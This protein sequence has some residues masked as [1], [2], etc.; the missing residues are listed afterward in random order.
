MENL[1]TRRTF[2]KTAGAAALAAGSMATASALAAPAAPP[3]LADDEPVAVYEADVVIAGS[4]GCG[5][6][7]AARAAQLG[8]RAL[9]VEQSDFPGGT[10]MCTEGLFAVGTH[11]QAE[12]GIDLTVAQ[13]FSQSMDFN[14]WEADGALAMEFFSSSADNFDW[15]EDLGVSF[16]YAIPNGASLPTWHVYEKDDSG[17]PGALYMNTLVQAGIDAGAQYLLSTSAQELVV[18]GGKVA[19]LLCTTAEGTVRVDAPVVV[20]ATGG[21]SNNGDMIRTY[22]GIDPGRCIPAGLGERNG[23]GIAMGL[24]AGGQMCAYPGCI[25]FYG[26]QPDGA[27]FGTPMFAA[28]TASPI[29]W[30]NGH[31]KR[32]TS[33]EWAA[34]NFSYSGN[35]IKGQDAVWS[36]INDAIVD[37]FV[38][39]GVYNDMGEYFALGQALPTLP[40]DIAALLESNPETTVRAD[41]VEEL[42][43]AIGCDSEVLAAT[44]KE[45]NACCAAGEDAAF[46]K[47]AQ[48]LIPVEGGAYYACKLKLG[49]F[50]TCGG[51]KVDTESRVLDAAGN[52]IGGLY[53]GG[54]DAGGLY[55]A[56]YDVN[57][58]TGSQ[59]GWAVHSGKRAA[60]SAARYLGVTSQE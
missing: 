28:F 6:A 41:T 29:L 3:S 45:Y 31:G 53:A 13:C 5:A 19:G 36:I 17:L 60:E 16:K 55:G 20:L 47:P 33:E 44:L 15:L 27:A 51:L 43:E 1:A 32:F 2:I 34:T 23:E 25:M 37:H 56:T 9:V 52:P 50:T 12:G 54:S 58:C 35:S 46:G 21:F 38:N 7:A 49:M 8:L 42:A 22:A 57:V 26:G 40:D 30:V 24:A 39:Q 48:W 11:L 59:Q 4:G 14:H 18:S 10:S